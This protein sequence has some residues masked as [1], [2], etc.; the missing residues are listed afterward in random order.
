MPVRSP[1]VPAAHLRQ[2]ETLVD[3]VLG[4]YVPCGH[5]VHATAFVVSM[6]VPTGHD[7][8]AVLP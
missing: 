4:L 5:G 1:Y 8:H 7:V 6:Y 3:P 2:A